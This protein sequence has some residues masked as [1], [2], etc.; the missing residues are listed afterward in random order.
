M[1]R[2]SSGDAM[3]L[4]FGTVHR[5]RD[6]SQ[7]QFDILQ[8]VQLPYLQDEMRSVVLQYQLEEEISGVTHFNLSHITELY[9]AEFYKVETMPAF[10]KERVVNNLA[11]HVQKF[12]KDIILVHKLVAKSWSMAEEIFELV[13]NTPISHTCIS[14]LMEAGLTKLS[15]KTCTDEHYKVPTCFNYCEETISACLAPYSSIVE[16]LYQWIN[17]NVKVQAIVSSRIGQKS[18][19]KIKNELYNVLDIELNDSFYRDVCE[20]HFAKQKTQ[21]EIN[22]SDLSNNDI[23]HI[24]TAAPNKRVKRIAKI[25][26]VPPT[27][28]YSTRFVSSQPVSSEPIHPIIKHNELFNTQMICFNA[29]KIITNKECWNGTNEGSYE[30]TPK[31]SSAPYQLFSGHLPKIKIKLKALEYFIAYIEDQGRESD[32]T[33]PS[34]PDFMVESRGRGVCVQTVVFILSIMLLIV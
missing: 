10:C 26:T 11:I 6:I 25:T 22:G 20:Y 8:E 16:L 24:A 23:Y 1:F 4:L 19:D 31:L 7:K 29:T 5:M 12:V 30:Q 32:I 17:N 33:A 21:D 13:L 2:H 15:C 3:S 9:M 18:Y 34:D 28:V 27:D 14:S